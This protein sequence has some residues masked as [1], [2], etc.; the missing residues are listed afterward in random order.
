LHRE[1]RPS[2]YVNTS[3]NLFYCHGCGVGGDLI[4]FIQLFLNL[5]F[6]ETIAHLQRQIGLPEQAEYE[7]LGEAANFYQRLLGSHQQAIDYLHSRGLHDPNLIQRLR[8]GYAPGALLRRHLSAQGFSLDLLLKLGLIDDQRRDTFYR[9]I[10]F[11]C[12]DAGCTINLYGRSITAG[13]APH[14]FLP[15]SKGGLYAWD[16]VSN[17]TDIILVEGLFDL[18]ALWQAG[19]LNTTCAFGVYLTSIQFSQISNRQDRMIFI[20]FDSDP[21]GSQA[22]LHLARRLCSAGLRA[23]IV[24]LPAGHDPNSYFASRASTLQ[25]EACLRNARH[26]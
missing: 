20:A 4:R 21:A 19:F 14:R 5:S 15:R 3:K 1:S 8:I 18:A 6:Q 24:D 26:V 9:R 13:A 17:F 12:F 2:F 7:V 23:S 10:I 22:A 25:F 11:P 16:T